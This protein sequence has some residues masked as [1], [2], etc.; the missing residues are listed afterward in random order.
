LLGL[1]KEAS[2][3]QHLAV[4]QVN[5]WDIDPLVRRLGPCFSGPPLENQFALRKWGLAFA[6]E[7]DIV[8]GSVSIFVREFASINILMLVEPTF[9]PI[10]SLVQPKRHIVW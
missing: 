3:K 5:D 9:Q 10:T 8:K 4:I 2:G 6:W 7:K 1:C